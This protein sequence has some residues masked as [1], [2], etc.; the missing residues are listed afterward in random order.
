LIVY[1]IVRK[2]NQHRPRRYSDEEILGA[3]RETQG[4]PY[5]A[6]ERLGCHANTIYYRAKQNPEIWETVYKFR[7]RMIDT[8]ELQL[9][10]AV[11]RGEPWAVQFALRTIGKDRGYFERSETH[12]IVGK[13]SD[14]EL[15]GR[16]QEL[17]QLAQ[18]TVHALPGSGAEGSDDPQ[19]V[20][21]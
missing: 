21:E 5:L 12:A 3:L 7:G 9:L 14:A 6:A 17:A 19:D 1:L 8:A 13:M 16:I 18:R 20:G 11:Q 2:K 10:S 4:A 15:V